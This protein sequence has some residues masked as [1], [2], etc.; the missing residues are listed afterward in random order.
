M[1]LPTSRLSFVLAQECSMGTLGFEPRASP[2][3]R[4]TETGFGMC[5]AD[6]HP[7]LLPTQSGRS[8]E[9]NYVPYSE[10]QIV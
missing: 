2:G 1:Y 9:L 3:G 10:N 8:A 7:T 6:S 5:R 4:I